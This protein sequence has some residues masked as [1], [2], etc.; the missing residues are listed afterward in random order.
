MSNQRQSGENAGG[1][2][3]SLLGQVSEKNRGIDE[4][5]SVVIVGERGSG[6]SSVVQQLRRLCHLRSEDEQA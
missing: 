4:T 6:R 3:Q 2:W 5:K 1:L